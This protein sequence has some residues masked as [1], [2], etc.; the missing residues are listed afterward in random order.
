MILDVLGTALAPRAVDLGTHAVALG[1]HACGLGGAGDESS[2]GG[3]GAGLG[4]DLVPWP[5]LCRSQ[6]ACGCRHPDDPRPVPR[7]QPW[8]CGLR[9]TAAAGVTGV[10]GLGIGRSS[11]LR[12]NTLGHN[13]SLRFNN[14][15]DGPSALIGVGAGP[16]G[17]VA[18]CAG[19]NLEQRS[20]PTIARL[21]TQTVSGLDP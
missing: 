1:Q 13:R 9:L 18:S 14:V 20:A 15:L 7:Q 8:P 2:H 11:W 6:E 12:G 19:N 4:M 10:S 5:L 17:I 16:P 21:L 3:R